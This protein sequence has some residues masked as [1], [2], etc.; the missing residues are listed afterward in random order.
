MSVVFTHYGSP[1][2]CELGGNKRQTMSS[3]AESE[4]RNA[5]LGSESWPQRRSPLVMKPFSDRQNSV[6]DQDGPVMYPVFPQ[7]LE[8]SRTATTQ[9][10][11]VG[12]RKILTG[13]A[14]QA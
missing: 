6:T 3:E 12:K 8:A 4:L 9:H 11:L 10:S 2:I 7:T 5:M 13:T 14:R 1:V